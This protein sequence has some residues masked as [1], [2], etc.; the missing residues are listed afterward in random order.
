[1]EEEIWK[2]WEGGGCEQRIGWVGIGGKKGGEVGEVE[3]WE[4]WWAGSDQ[5]AAWIGRLS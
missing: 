5:Y 3:R 4:R 2:S 1:M